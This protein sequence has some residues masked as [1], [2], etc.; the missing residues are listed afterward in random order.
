MVAGGT[1]TINGRVTR[2]VRAAG[3]D[4][5]VNGHIEGDLIIA[6]GRLDVSSRA[7]IGKDLIL[8]AGS[9]HIYG[10]VEGKIK[11]FGSDV[12]L[13]GTDRHP[14]ARPAPWPI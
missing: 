13:A 14:S 8:A 3:G 10:P 7:T 4:L 6:G 12:V 9:A 2:A 1:V 11:G 5:F